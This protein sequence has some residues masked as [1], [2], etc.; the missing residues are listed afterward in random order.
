MAFEICNFVCL[1]T[2][3]FFFIFFSVLWLTEVVIMQVDVTEDFEGRL[4]YLF[5]TPF[6]RSS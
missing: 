4:V 3:L 6:P 2:Y 1:L 5:L